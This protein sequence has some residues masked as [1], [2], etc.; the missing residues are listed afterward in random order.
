MSELGSRSWSTEPAANV[1]VIYHSRK[2][3]QHALALAAAAGAR[4]AGATVRLLRIP[5]ID[6]DSQVL[7]DDDG[8][9]PP[10]PT[11]D[12]LLWA[13]GIVWG[14]PTHYGNVSAS[15]KRFIDSTS[16][17]WSRGLLADCAVTGMTSST[18]PNGGQEATLSAL[19]RSMYH[20][21]A[22]VMSADPAAPGWQ[23]TG[24]NPF[25][26]SVCAS[27]GKILDVEENAAQE[28]GRRVA[29]L[30]GRV[31]ALRDHRIRGQTMRGLRQGRTTRVA[32]LFQDGDAALAQ[33]AEALAAGVRDAGG[34]VRMRRI[35]CLAG[36]DGPD[37]GATATTPAI[38]LA[39]PHD[40]AWADA[41]AWGAHPA[42]GSAPPELMRFLQ[43]TEAALPAE[44]YS[45]KA[46][47]AF[48]TTLDVH[49]GGESM[50]L[51]VYT[52]MHTWSAL[53]VAPGYTDPVVTVAGGN[54]Y[55]T[56]HVARDGLRKDDV[57]AAARHQGFRLA[58]VTQR[59]G[60]A[61]PPD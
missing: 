55:G 46:V 12:D 51:S 45:N 8:R 47:T 14:T 34:D 2:G 13:D 5:A 16:D 10:A 23:A 52:A 48:G 42:A 37:H 61:G 25:G 56:L 21:G 29:R 60:P 35:P 3:T 1:A 9:R 53:I 20:W 44:R 39:D 38:P 24:A 27:Y 11:H 17:L 50:L 26:L 7:F 19:Y 6:A 57:L 32:V 36:G 33:L 4:D 18:S 54:P 28:T 59:I 30:A 31:R 43:A 15:F 41:L 22:L 49:A 40:V 58:A